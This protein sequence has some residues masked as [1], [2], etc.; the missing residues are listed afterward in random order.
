MYVR[1][2]QF[3]RKAILLKIKGTGTYSG[4]NPVN[5]HTLFEHHVT[6]WFDSILPLQSE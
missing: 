2:E 3:K 5:I 4:E 1:R 6:N